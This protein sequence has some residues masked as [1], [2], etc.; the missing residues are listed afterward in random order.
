MTHDDIYIHNNV[1]KK[2]QKLLNILS[3]LM[4]NEQK[5]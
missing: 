5:Y 1:E 3:H 2:I 4:L